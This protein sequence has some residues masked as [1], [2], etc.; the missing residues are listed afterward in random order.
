MKHLF[1]IPILML[2][3]IASMSHAQDADELGDRTR[4]LIEQLSDDSWQTRNQAS[5]ELLGLN[6][7]P[8]Q[9]ASLEALEAYVNDP[10]LT[11]EARARLIGVCFARFRGAPK[12]G[13]GVAF[14]AVSPGSIEI[15]P[16]QRDARFPASAMLN[17]GDAIAMIDNE[18]LMDSLDLRA[19]ILSRAPG[20]SLPATIIRNNTLIE[21]DLPLGSLDH[22]A[23]A[24]S[25]DVRLT[26]RALDLRWQR[27]GITRNTTDTAGEQ[28]S[29]SQWQSAAFPQRTTSSP[30]SP[31]TRIPSAKIT[32]VHRL[33]RTGNFQPRRVQLWDSLGSLSKKLIEHE[34]LLKSRYRLRYEA[35]RS[36]LETQGDMLNTEFNAAQGA[37]EIQRLTDE[38]NVIDNKLHELDKQAARFDD[39]L[40]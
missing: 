7:E 29:V 17:P 16:I 26:W 3:L 22:L 5:F 19:H 34:T 13:L 9:R 12:G 8:D 28:I 32:G 38:M 35:E 15:D 30:R 21:M 24:A 10:T 2:V 33:I 18:M 36:L 31:N 14:G 37:V 6:M 25:M 39:L 11:L 1:L 27:L 20:G 40:K 23:G 4:S